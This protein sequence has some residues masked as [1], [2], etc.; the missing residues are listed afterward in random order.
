MGPRD[1]FFLVCLTFWKAFLSF[2]LP[3]Y[4]VISDLLLIFYY[5][6][7]PSS[8]IQ[9]DIAAVISIF[10]LPF[11]AL[12]SISLADSWGAFILSLCH[13]RVQWDLLK[14][15]PWL[16]LLPVTIR[17]LF[18]VKRIE[19]IKFRSGESTH[20][21]SEAQKPEMRCSF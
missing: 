16:Y 1:L 7:V 4:C 9:A 11:L 3:S 19:E 8:I 14:L 20:E 15:I 21:H 6:P 17:S 18:A 5:S 2:L 10:S 13:D 12:P